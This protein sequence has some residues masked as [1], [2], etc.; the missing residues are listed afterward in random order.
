MARPIVVAKLRGLGASLAGS[1]NIR[2]SSRRLVAADRADR[3]V[4]DVDIG[5]APAS[6]TTLPLCNVSGGLSITR[7][8]GRQPSRHLD[9]VA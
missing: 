3:A 1:R 7:T 5:V 4:A 6:W 2:E 9:A 8:L